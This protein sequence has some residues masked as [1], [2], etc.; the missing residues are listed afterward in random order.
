MFGQRKVIA[1]A[2]QGMIVMAGNGTLEAAKAL[3]WSKIAAAVDDDLNQAQL[4][5]YGLAD[6]IVKKL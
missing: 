4:A 2:K 5:A 1:V 6:K 3:G